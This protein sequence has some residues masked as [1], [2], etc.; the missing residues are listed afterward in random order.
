MAPYDPRSAWTD[1]GPARPLS[2]WQPGEPIGTV[3]HYIGANGHFNPADHAGCL[4]W[5]RN[6]EAA[7]EGG[8]VGTHDVYSALSYNICACPHGRVIEGRGIQFQSGS[9]LGGNFDHVGL[10][11]M[12]SV[13]DKMTDQL[14]TAGRA[15]IDIVLARY[16]QA[17]GLAGHRDIAGNPTGTVC[18]GVYVEAWV[19]AGAPAPGSFHPLPVKV[20]PDMYVNT[21]SPIVSYLARAQ[22]AWIL[23][24]DGGILTMAGKYYGGPFGKPYFANRKGARLIAN[25]NV[26]KRNRH[27]YVVVAQTGEK[28]GIDGF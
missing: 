2:P 15:A 19:R 25:P 23:L 9:Q 20:K 24:E 21:G 3:V 6:T 27:P 1:K 11:M 8:N 26:F 16:P 18:P 7:E 17:K 4:A 14:A 12:M 5:C 13:D 28:Y 22:G 10:L